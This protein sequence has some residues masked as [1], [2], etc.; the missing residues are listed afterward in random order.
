MPDKIYL[1]ASPSLHVENVAQIDGY[2]ESTRHLLSPTE[3]AFAEAYAGISKV[4]DARAAAKRNPVWNEAEQLIQT[5]AL[6]LWL[7]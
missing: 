3:I 7:V 4:H 6:A 5:Q 2:D 1:R